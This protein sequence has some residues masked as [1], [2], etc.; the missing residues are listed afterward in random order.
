[1]YDA[2]I[3]GVRNCKSAPIGLR[4]QIFHFGA[5][6]FTF[7]VERTDSLRVGAVFSIVGSSFGVVLFFRTFFDSLKELQTKNLLPQVNIFAAKPL[8]V[9]LAYFEGNTKICI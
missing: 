4:S 1:M 6:I 2:S 5:L 3:W 8:Y 9:H 7:K